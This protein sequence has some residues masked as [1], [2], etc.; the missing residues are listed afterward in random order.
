MS[1]D[2]PLYLLSLDGG[3][4]RGISELVIL[5]EIMK[6]LQKMAGLREIPKPQDHFHLMGGTSTEGVSWSFQHAV[7]QNVTNSRSLE[8]LIAI[9]L[10]RMGMSTEEAIN[11]SESFA[12]DVFHPKNRRFWS[13]T[14]KEK[15]LVKII[16]D[17]VR[18][19]ATTT[20][21]DDAR[22]KGLTFVC[23]ATYE[24]YAAYLFRTYKGS[25]N[26]AHNVEIW[27]AA[28][29]TSAA[30]TFFD[31]ISIKVEAERDQYVDGAVAYNNPARLVLSEAE[32]Y[33]GPRRTLGFLLSL[34]TGLKVSDKEV[35]V[36]PPGQPIDRPVV[37]RQG[38]GALFSRGTIKIVK[39][40]KASLTDSEPEHQALEERFLGTPYAY[41]RL[42]LDRGAADIKLNEYQKMGL[43]RAATER[44]IQDFEVSAS[45]DKIASMLYKKEGVNMSLDAACHAVSEAASRQ[46]VQQEVQINSIASPQ[47]TGR[48]DI[49]SKMERHFFERPAGSSPRRHLRIWGVGGVGKTQIVLRFRDLYGSRFDLV[50]RINGATITSMIESFR[51]LTAEIFGG[52]PSRPDMKKV[53]NWLAQNHTEEWLLVFDNNDSIDVSQYIPPGNVGNIIFTSRRKDITPTLDADQTIPVDIMDA[54]DAVT[55]FL[56][57]SKR[58][59]TKSGDA[60]DRY[61]R[62]IVSELG[63]L[64]LAID[65][66]GSYIYNQECSFASYLV[67]FRDRR[68]DI[69]GDP[70][71]PGVFEH[72]PA[73]YGTFELSYVALEKRSQQNSHN[74]RAALNALRILNIFCFYHNEKITSAILRRAAVSRKWDVSPFRSER[75]DNGIGPFPLINITREGDWDPTNFEN[76]IATL[77]SYSLIK[78]S[79]LAGWLYSMHVLVHSW[80]RDRMK[81]DTLTMQRR[82]AG[83]IL[84]LASA[85]NKTFDAEI[86]R[87]EVLPHMQACF[88]HGSLEFMKLTRETHR[89]GAFSSVLM[90]LGLWTQ[91]TRVLEE[92]VAASQVIFEP[93][94]MD[95]IAASWDLARAYRDSSRLKESQALFQDIIRLVADH[96][97]IRVVRHHPRIGIDLVELSII[98]ARYK[99]A[100][101]LLATLLE[102]GEEV[103]RDGPW[104]GGWWRKTVRTLATIFRME[105]NAGMAYGID[106]SYL[107]YCVENKIHSLATASALSSVAASCSALEEHNEADRTWREVLAIEEG[108]DNKSRILPS[109]RD[110]ATGCANLNQFEEAEKILREVLEVS[111]KFLWRTH[112]DTLATMDQLAGVLARCQKTEGA[113]RL[114][115]ECLDGW[116][117]ILREQHPLKQ[118]TRWALEKIRNGDTGLAQED[119]QAGGCM[120]SGGCYFLPKEVPNRDGR[121]L[122]WM[123]QLE[124]LKLFPPEL[125]G[126]ADTRDGV[127]S[128]KA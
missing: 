51:L 81:P 87:P 127:E 28:R 119:F 16:Q 85:R 79:T 78:R 97:E 5:H 53:H 20:M 33:F 45:I 89:E 54:E 52:E 18:K 59:R 36:V 25:S 38:S 12:E 37:A 1:Q 19:L 62:E 31:P 105:G 118:R 29:A 107:Q 74:G 65:Q 50:F 94:D 90:D 44:Y 7:L 3:G 84:Y 114:W 48:L 32:S 27:E 22:E 120:F 88:E 92:I 110:V 126:D 4:I 99:E 101:D 106:I 128:A 23:S 58:Q 71:Y 17:N 8:R 70:M 91:A 102:Y 100:K 103:G 124:V 104:S 73:V 72:N 46:A 56:R 82:A 83:E 108:L 14:Y 41:W 109:K 2:E 122:T 86:F 24:N 117:H 116:E 13:R 61:E 43:L 125:E 96:G 68:K 40:A 80:A 77:R 49:L 112:L 6:R 75:G 98:Q 95:S 63:Y 11:A 39:H 21:L 67:N 47:F 111:E 26:C 115:E 121:L 66:A 35:N 10:G 69:I 42:N 76:G 30:P 15:T 55:L 9:M 123:S 64:P 60:D 93:Q 57:A 34:G 113:V